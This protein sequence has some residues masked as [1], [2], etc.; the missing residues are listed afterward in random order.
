MGGILLMNSGHR[1]FIAGGQR[2]GRS[3]ALAMMLKRSPEQKVLVSNKRSEA[4][5]L[6]LGVRG[7]QIV[8]LSDLKRVNTDPY[9]AVWRG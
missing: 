8:C 6:E 1:L 3:T 9:N 5:F 2:S 4:L 7:E